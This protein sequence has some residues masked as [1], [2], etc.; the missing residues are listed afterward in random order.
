MPRRRKRLLRL[1]FAAAVCAAAVGVALYAGLPWLARRQAVA[2]LE[3]AGFQ[4]VELDVRAAG[5]WRTDLRDVSLGRG[6]GVRIR[7]VEARYR[8]VEAVRGR[9]ASL[10]LT[11]AV[12]HLAMD[13]GRVDWG[14]LAELDTG[15]PAD[16]PVERVAVRDSRV[17]FDWNG[18]SEDISFGATLEK[19]AGRWQLDATADWQGLHLHVRTPIDLETGTAPDL[20]VDVQG[21]TAAT[22]A[23]L[24]ERSG[25]KLPVRPKGDLSVTASGA[26]D[27]AGASGT[28]TVTSPVLQASL[29]LADG[30]QLDAAVDKVRLEL[31]LAR[32]EATGPRTHAKVTAER[33]TVT[34]MGLVCEAEDLETELREFEST[35][36]SGTGGFARGTVE[37]GKRRA[38]LDKASWKLAGQRL[39]GQASGNVPNVAPFALSG[40]LTRNAKGI[41]GELEVDIPR[42]S[43]TEETKL[44]T[45]DPR[46]AAYRFAGDVTLKGRIQWEAGKTSERLEV[47]LDDL[48]AAQKQGN[49]GLK[50]LSGTL[51]FS[52]LAPLQTAGVQRLTVAELYTGIFKG[53][54]AR[55]DLEVEN[56][57]SIRIQRAECTWAGGKVWAADARIRRMHPHADPGG[58]RF[59]RAD[60][61]VHAEGLRLQELL[62][63][64]YPGRVKGKGRMY[65]ELPV[66]YQSNRRLPVFGEGFLEARPPTGWLQFQEE[67]AK[68]LLGIETVVPLEKA[69]TQEVAKLLAM[70]ALQDFAYEALRCEFLKTEKQGWIGRVTVRGHGPRGED[71]IPIGGLTITDNDLDR[72]LYLAMFEYR[73]E[74]WRA[75]FQKREDKRADQRKKKETET[76]AINQFF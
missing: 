74:E 67:D 3:A 73:P 25:L 23:A 55:V 68:L 9:L 36:R 32:P 15:G 60:V 2:A 7:S 27:S 30:E 76:D 41:S 56:S 72:W 42:F 8:P 46:L 10:V 58:E 69:T 44:E 61:K 65:G 35:A 47:Q 28:V 4:R 1:A 43:L 5:L 71:P 66:T 39:T 48:D 49:A 20:Y 13:E 24:A 22:V 17:T 29:P 59:W 57:E 14:A 37:A 62:D 18:A 51:T 38:T 53:T 75:R 54:D 6:G 33:L 19:R 45:V 34:G 40:A 31:R 12:V 11:G 70:R 26:F 64:V 63:L 16:L 50:G 21:L 52:G